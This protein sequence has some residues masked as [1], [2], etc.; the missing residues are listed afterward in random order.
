M[1]VN[2]YTYTGEALTASFE[3]RKYQAYQDSRGTWTIGVGHTG[4]E[5]HEGL[6]WT[7][8]QIDSAFL[9]DSQWAQSTVNQE[10]TVP[11][12]QDENNALVDLIFNIGRGNFDSSTL[13]RELNAGQYELAAAQFDRWD[14]SGGVELA[15]LLRRRQAET[16]LFEQG[17]SFIS[18]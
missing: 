16:A 4:P 1:G 9:A 6:V 17:E 13:L 11:I 5:V 2:N 7:D 18:G 8:A 3:G 14:R 12:T 15:G 10:V